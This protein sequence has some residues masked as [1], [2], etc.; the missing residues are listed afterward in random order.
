[1][2]E[3]TSV[4]LSAEVLDGIDKLV[5]GIDKLS[6]TKHSRSAMIERVLREYL[7]EHGKARLRA[8]D[9]ELLNQEADRLNAE[10]ADVLDFQAAESGSE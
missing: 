5:D 8:R 10:A 9:L 2:K 3:K 6:G 1:M 4:T 7:R